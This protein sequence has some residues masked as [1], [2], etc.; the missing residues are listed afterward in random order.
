MNTPIEKLTT[1]IASAIWADGV[2]D[3]AEAVTVEEIAEALELD[4]ASFKAAIDT[5]IA[6]L[7]TL[8][9]EEV[10]NRLFAAAQA[11]EDEEI[12][13]VFQS[14]MQIIISDN[15]LCRP[16]V[17]N[18]LVLADALGIEDEDAVLMIADLVKDEPELEVV[19]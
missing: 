17:N 13:I 10:D 15:E 2:Y 14:A 12:G 3:E 1:I 16:E 7:Q 5:E 4:E 8:S 19:L 11:V 9:D 18:L 6:T